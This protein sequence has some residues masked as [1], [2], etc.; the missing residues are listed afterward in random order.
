M[1]DRFGAE[2]AALGHG[3][4]ELA[5]EFRE[6]RGIAFRIV[7][8]AL[9]KLLRQQHDVL[10]EKAEDDA[11]E[12]TRH[13]VRRFAALAQSLGD[14][15]DLAGGLGGDGLAGDAGLEFL[16][17]EENRRVSRYRGSPSS[18]SGMVKTRLAMAVKLV[19][20]MIRSRSQTTSS[21][22]FSS[23]SRYCRSWS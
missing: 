23:A 11:V 21:G 6:A 9:K 5:D 14:L 18:A 19:W 4:E 2:I 3:V 8:D 17:I 1:P 22:G 7:E 20:T 10:G 16:G 15:G 13:V 12:E